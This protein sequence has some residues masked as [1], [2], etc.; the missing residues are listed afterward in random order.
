MP[1]IPNKRRLT[2]KRITVAI[3]EDNVTM[4]KGMKAELDRPDISIC[5]VTNHVDQFL[6]ELESCQPH[7]AI[8]DLRICQDF[9]AGFGVIARARDISPAT[10]YIVHTAYDMIENFHNGIN[11]GIKAFVSKNI[12]EKPLDEVVQL[13]FNGGTYY[14]DLLPQYLNKLK[15]NTLP[16]SF[17]NEKMLANSDFSKTELEVLDLLDQGKS[18]EEIAEQRVVSVNTIKAQTRSIRGK[19]G[20]GTTNEALRLYRLRRRDHE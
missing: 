11:L 5:S 1:K 20:V 12:Y 8:V 4:V 3:L 2:T 13:V 7:I 14:G 10:Q 6:E 18:I 16:L 15:E 17:Q 19:L 9:E